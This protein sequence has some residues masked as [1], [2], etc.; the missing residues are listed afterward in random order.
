MILD[1]RVLR[2]IIKNLKITGKTLTIVNRI[3]S[4]NVVSDYEEETKAFI[5]ILSS[6]INKFGINSS[7]FS[8]FK[9]FFVNYIRKR[10]QEK[11]FLEQVLLVYNVV[12][13]NSEY[14]LPVREIFP[15]LKYKEIKLHELKIKNGVAFFDEKEFSEIISY[16]ILYTF[17]K[18]LSE[19][20]IKY[21]MEFVTKHFERE[22]FKKSISLIHT[23]KLVFEAFPPCIKRALSGVEKGSR[24]FAIVMLLT[25]FLSR[26]RLGK[27]DPNARIENE[28][29]VRILKEEIIPIIE[30]AAENCKPPLFE[31]QP[32]ER[33]NIVYHLGFGYKEDFSLKD[34]GESK[35]YMTPNCDKIKL[36]AP[37]LCMED[38]F[39]LSIKNPLSYYF[40]KIKGLKEKPGSPSG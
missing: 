12:K 33:K 25:T 18:I 24:N 34:F 38:D 31:D 9:K 11:E 8:E 1:I 35:W 26:A 10:I 17:E 19:M 40:K 39:C 13:R 7:E 6:I 21:S 30:R 5:I 2:N 29:E 32:Y 37:D 20:N 22:V 16:K 3:L 4:G 15:L 23:G 28:N 36:Q 14:I 27:M